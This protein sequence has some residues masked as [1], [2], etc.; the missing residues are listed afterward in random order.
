M[1][2]ETIKQNVL[3]LQGFK[4]ELRKDIL[5]NFNNY[6]KSQ[7]NLKD[8]TE[9]G[10]KITKKGLKSYIYLSTVEM[11]K[12][13]NGISSLFQMFKADRYSD[14]EYIIRNKKVLMSLFKDEKEIYNKIR[15]SYNKLKGVLKE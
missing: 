7:R 6:K 3:R 4:D 5:E 10:F 14:K 1:K 12:K 9:K 15:Y 13:S 11:K 2:R 8:T